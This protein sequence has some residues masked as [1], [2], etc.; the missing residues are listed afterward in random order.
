MSRKVEKLSFYREPQ[1]IFANYQAEE[2]AVFLDSSLENEM[3]RYSIIGVSPRMV[4]SE[5]DGVCRCNGIVQSVDILTRMQKELD[6]LAKDY[7]NP[8]ELPLTAGAI[9]YF[10]YEYGRKKLGVKSKHVL[11]DTM[12]DA[13]FCF[14]HIL[15]IADVKEKVLYA[16]VDDEKNVREKIRQLTKELEMVTPQILLKKQSQL[17]KTKK[18]F[19]QKTYG[20]ALQKMIQYMRDGHIYVANMTQQ[21]CVASKKKPFDVYRYLRT[22]NPAPFSAYLNYGTFQVACASPERFLRKKKNI[23]TTRPIKGTRKR[24]ESIEQDQFLRAELEQSEKDR[25]ELLMIM[26]LERN[27]LNRICVPGS[28]KVTDP[29]VIEEYATVFHL[30][31]EIQGEVRPDLQL[32]DFVRSLFPGG[33]ITGAPKIRAMEIIDELER[34]SRGLYTGNIG[35]FA[36]DGSCDFNIVIRTAIY[37]GENYHIGAGGGITYESDVAFEYEETLQKAKALLEAIYEED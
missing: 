20:Q 11:E 14:Y 23:I 29:F 2:M 7:E 3:G 1:D 25:S 6:N 18:R 15:I 22:Y 32:K 35:Y 24:G 37:E 31:S 8:Y 34:E 13:M 21:F 26:D 30:V 4:L 28:V 36:G 16:V 5:T 9:G 17:A 19:T 10:S 33:S 27:D 12:P